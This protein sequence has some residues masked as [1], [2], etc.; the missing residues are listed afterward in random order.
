MKKIVLVGAILFSGLLIADEYEDKLE[1]A[2]A[3]IAAK[4][5]NKITNTAN[6]T[7][8]SDEKNLKGFVLSTDIASFDDIGKNIDAQIQQM[9]EETKMLITQVALDMELHKDSSGIL[10]LNDDGTILYTPKEGLPQ[11]LNDKRKKLVE[12]NLKNSVSIR[13]A[14]LAFKLLSDLNEEI[15]QKALTAKTKDDKQKL[16]M[17]QAIFVYEM[18]DIVIVLLDKLSLNGKGDLQAL[19]K[20]TKTKIRTRVEEIETQEQ[21]KRELAQNNE[22]S[23]AQ[24]DASLKSLDAMIQAQN[25]TMKM[26]EETMKKVGDMDK[27]LENI[28]SKNRLLKSYQQDAK[29]QIATLRDMQTISAI[30]D[31]IGS[32]DELLASV[33]S[34]ELLVLDEKTVSQLLGIDFK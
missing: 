6:D 26:W 20:E 29:L 11:T 13:S 27:F 12:A 33:N 21:N 4:Q 5:V 24:L 17:Q 10:Q 14:S 22:I 30:K 34:L 2:M 19:Y 28:K 1:A 32:F 31:S 8:S 3:K 18:S 23:Q 7:N 25:S 9:K 15:K 16:F